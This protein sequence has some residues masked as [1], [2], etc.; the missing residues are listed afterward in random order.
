M[1]DTSDFSNFVKHQS[2]SGK[3][4]RLP[5]RCAPIA[6]RELHRKFR[7]SVEGAARD[8]GLPDQSTFPGFSPFKAASCW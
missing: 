1:S 5:L 8:R 3:M 2:C 7:A 4:C 6:L